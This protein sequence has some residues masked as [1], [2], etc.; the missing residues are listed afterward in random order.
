MTDGANVNH[1]AQPAPGD[2]QTD[3]TSRTTSRRKTLDRPHTEATAGTDSD[4]DQC[5]TTAEAPWDDGTGSAPGWRRTQCQIRMH[6]AAGLTIAWK[7]CTGAAPDRW[8]TRCLGWREAEAGTASDLADD[9]SES[10][11]CRK[12][13]HISSTSRPLSL[14]PP[15]PS[16]SPPIPL[17]H[18][19]RGR[20]CT[21]GFPGDR[22]FSLGGTGGIHPL[23][24]PSYIHS[25]HHSRSLT[26]PPTRPAV[27]RLRRAPTSIGTDVGDAIGAAT[28]GPSHPSFNHQQ[29]RHAAGLSLS[30]R[31]LTRQA[32]PLGVA[33]ERDVDCPD[34]SLP[35]PPSPSPTFVSIFT[36]TS[37][38]PIHTTHT[39]THTHIHTHTCLSAPQRQAKL[40]SI[41]VPRA[42]SRTVD[43]TPP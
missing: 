16:H 18:T 23:Y 22:F 14:F 26:R 15:Y 4:L 13:A 27:H 24:T 42:T 39:R 19:P 7:C 33:A 29:Q 8:R 5:T 36:D 21:L 3:A 6:G 32:S 41:P 40:C 30:A 12:R 25:L 11:L 1:A 10:A 31:W 34:T 37:L 28:M 9:R 17:R 35:P 38:A 20:R 2:A 43:Q